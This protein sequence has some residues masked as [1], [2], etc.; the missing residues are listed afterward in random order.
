MMSMTTMQC[1]VYFNFFFMYV[2]RTLPAVFKKQIQGKKINSHIRLIAKPAYYNRLIFSLLIHF[3]EYG[4][5]LYMQ[6]KICLSRS[7]KTE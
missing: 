7:K 4:Y 2:L 3:F 6:Q 1:N 5:A